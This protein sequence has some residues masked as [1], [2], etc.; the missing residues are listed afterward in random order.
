MMGSEL[1]LHLDVNGTEVVAVV[2][3]AGTGNKL[4]TVEI[5]LFPEHFHLFDCENEE[6]LLYGPAAVSV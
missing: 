4:D 2:P 5:Q 6:S 3:T 1:H